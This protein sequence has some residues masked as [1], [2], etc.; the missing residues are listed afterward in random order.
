MIVK[1]E[2]DTIAKKIDLS[3]P[4]DISIPLNASPEN[5][6]AW[7]LNEPK[8]APVKDGDWIGKVSEGASVNF[9]TIE[10]NPVIKYSLY[11]SVLD[12]ISLSM[13]NLPI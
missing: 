9:N 12:N 6:T 2:I 8:I 13:G 7:Y 1:L 11:W 4:L 10:F 3:K 5:P